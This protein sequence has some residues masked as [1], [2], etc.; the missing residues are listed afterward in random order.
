MI[1]CARTLHS[2]VTSMAH[3]ERLEHLVCFITA[4]ILCLGSRPMP[5]W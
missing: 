1:T 3:S 5:M 2:R 4:C